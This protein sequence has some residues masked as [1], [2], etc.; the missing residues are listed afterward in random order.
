MIDTESEPGAWGREMGMRPQYP[1]QRCGMRDVCERQSAELNA[2]RGRVVELEDLLCRY[3]NEV[4]LGHQP[5]MI[6]HL[7]DAALAGQK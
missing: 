3:R 4:P 5:H 7:V 6:A 2:L 1:I